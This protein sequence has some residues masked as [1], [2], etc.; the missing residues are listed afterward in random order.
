MYKH[1]I[2]D[3]EECALHDQEEI[4]ALLRKTRDLEYEYVKN[5]AVGGL[6]SLQHRN[7]PLY[8]DVPGGQVWDKYYRD[9]P[10]WIIDMEEA[11]KALL[12]KHAALLKEHAA[13]RSVL[14]N[15]SSSAATSSSKKK[16]AADAA[17]CANPKAKTKKAAA[18]KAR[19]SPAK[20]TKT[21]PKRKPASSP[22]KRASPAK[23]K[24]CTA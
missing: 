17:A 23:K 7:A 20:K 18:A 3:D 1:H 22:A 5:H 8:L 10:P 6:A 4:E 21:S 19:A 16:A 15:S 24:R 11:H 12:A 14:A 13:L 9:Q 2:R